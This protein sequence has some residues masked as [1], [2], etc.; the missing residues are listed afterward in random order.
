MKAELWD[1]YTC[2]EGEAVKAD[3]NI[4][5]AT[6]TLVPSMFYEACIQ[7]MI[8]YYV[9]GIPQ[10]AAIKVTNETRVSRSS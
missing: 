5:N 2:E 10:S 8:S 3:D 1:F 9:R 7:A 6:K 4:V